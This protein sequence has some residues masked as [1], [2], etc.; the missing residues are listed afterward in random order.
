MRKEE[1]VVGNELSYEVINA[2]YETQNK[3]GP[4]LLEK[5]YHN[6]LAIS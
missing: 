3:L 4:G 5:A 1:Q 2:F 6:G